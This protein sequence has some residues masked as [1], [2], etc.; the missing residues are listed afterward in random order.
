MKY[1]YYLIIQFFNKKLIFIFQILYFLNLQWFPQ[2]SRDKS[3]YKAVKQY[4]SPV[5]FPRTTSTTSS[6]W[7]QFTEKPTGAKRLTSWNGSRLSPKHWT[8][9]KLLTQNGFPEVN[10]T[11]L[12]TVGTVTSSSWDCQNTSPWSMSPP[13]PRSSS[14]SRIR[15]CTTK[16]RDSLKSFRNRGSK[17]EISSSS[18]CLWYLSP[19]SQVI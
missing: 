16:Y 15:N 8:N 7:T 9:R 19:S 5:A 1:F 4:T 3:Y 18:T 17:K 14:S 13:I 12:T 10:L 2:F 11:F 6:P